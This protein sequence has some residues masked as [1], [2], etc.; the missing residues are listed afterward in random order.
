MPVMPVSVVIRTTKFVPIR[1]LPMRSPSTFSIFMQRP[2]PR[3]RHRADGAGRAVSET[4]L[5]RCRRASGGR[6]DVS[7]GRLGPE[8]LAAAWYPH[9][10]AGND[11]SEV[12]GG[13]REER[14]PPAIAA[15][16]RRSTSR[17]VHGEGPAW[18]AASGVLLW[19]DMLAGRLHRTYPDGGDGVTEYDQ[20]VCVAVRASAAARRWRSATGSGSRNRTASCGGSLRYPAGARGPIRMNDGKC[21]PQGRSGRARWRTTLGRARGRCTGSTPTARSSSRCS[22]VTISNGL[23]WTP[24]GST[25]YYID[26][27]TGRVDAFDAD[28]ATGA[29]GRRGPRSGSN[30]KHGQP[31]GMT[32]DDDGACG[33][34]CGAA[35]RSTGTRRT[36]AWTAWSS[37]RAARSRV[38]R[39]VAADSTSCTS[40]PRRTGCRGRCSGQPLAGGLFRVRPGVPGPAAVAFAG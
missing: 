23:A 2:S 30:P 40:P 1:S 8:R 25:M 20:P 28:P 39:S 18:D 13:A 35:A 3:A 32:I 9:D 31:D 6:P 22:K 5:A 38:A 37:C 34:R 26:T 12:P 33:S 36:V 4:I 17:R 27:P 7:A 19:V 14:W 11:T 10:H 21:D 24:D 16:I 15:P 29:I